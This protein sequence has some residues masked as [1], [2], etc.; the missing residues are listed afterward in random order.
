M[1]ALEQ[2]S[3]WALSWFKHKKI[4]VYADK[5]QAM[6]LNKKENEGR[7][8]LTME[9]NDIESTKSVKLI[10]I[11]IGDCLKFDRHVSK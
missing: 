8:K 1:K 2:E 6:I 5:F 7:Y 3:D 11:T 9:N 10:V 4:I